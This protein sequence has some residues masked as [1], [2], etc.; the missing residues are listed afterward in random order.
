MI[1]YCR[2]NWLVAEAGQIRPLTADQRTQLTANIIDKMSTRG[3]RTIAIAFRDFVSLGIVVL[4]VI[5][6]VVVVMR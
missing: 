5:V 1:A 3:L 6:V 2:C 4:E